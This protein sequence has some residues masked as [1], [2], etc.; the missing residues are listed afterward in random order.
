MR[1]ITLLLLLAPFVLGSCRHFMG[2]RIRG[3]GEIK[4]ESRSVTDFKNIQVH[5]AVSVYIT[6]GPTQSV[7]ITGDENLMQYIEVTQEGD[8]LVVGERSGFNLDPT[9]ELK[10]DISSP[11]YHSISLSGASNIESENKITG[12]D[13]LELNLSGAGNI[14]LEVEV[15]KITADISGVGSMYIKGQTKDAELDLSGAGSAHCYDL[16]AENTKVEVSRGG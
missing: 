1:K 16:Q 2:R 6:Q 9:N 4:T 13:E 11:S 15:P 10:I 12:S 3:N 8:V 7:K 14:K 5:G